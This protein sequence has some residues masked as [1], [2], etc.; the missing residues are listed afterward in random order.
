M[1]TMLE[2]KTKEKP[3]PRFCPHCGRQEVVLAVVPYALQVKHDEVLHD[4]EIPHL[5]TSRCRSCGQM[6]FGNRADEQIS[7]AVRSQLHLLGPT[8]IRDSRNRLGLTLDVMAER[9]GVS[10]ELLSKWEED[11]AIQPRAADNLMRVF[12]AFSNVREVLTGKMQNP[13]LGVLVG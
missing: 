1:S 7:A 10:G 5:E 12:F 2:R 6:V 11:L 8:E 4:I 13:Q 3:F 9:L